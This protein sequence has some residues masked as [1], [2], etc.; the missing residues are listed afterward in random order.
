MKRSESLAPLSREHHSA[1][2]LA[3]LLKRG[4]PAYKDLP[5]SPRE[6]AAYAIKMFDDSLKEHFR[7]EEILIEKVEGC[8]EDI[9]KLGEEII[10]EHGQLTNAFNMLGK[11]TD[12]EVAMDQLGSELDKHI[13]KEERVLFP[14]IEKYCS[15]EV[16]RGIEF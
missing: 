11:E 12:L 8:H 16:L 6:K 13:R 1:L 15:E 14:L 2:I 7:K 3:Q 10:M 4:A 5:T 9:K